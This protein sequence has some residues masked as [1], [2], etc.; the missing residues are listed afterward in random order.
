MTPCEKRDEPVRNFNWGCHPPATVLA[1]LLA[2]RKEQFPFGAC[3]CL[4]G[5]HRRGWDNRFLRL[6]EAWNRRW[7]AN[8][9]SVYGVQFNGSMVLWGVYEQRGCDYRRSDNPK[10]LLHG[11]FG[12]PVS[13]TP[14]LTARQKRS[15]QSRNGG[16]SSHT[17]TPRPGTGP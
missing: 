6:V 17:A 16:A 11:I 4:P 7:S 8:H 2:T 1:C 5:L 13:A 12:S 10:I 15:R 3:H 14:V 9:D